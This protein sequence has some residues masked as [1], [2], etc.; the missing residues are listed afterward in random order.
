MGDRNVLAFAAK[1][2]NN[3]SGKTILYAGL[4]GSQVF[5][6][7]DLGDS[8]VDKGIFLPPR[9]IDAF[10]VCGNTIFAAGDDILFST[11]DGDSWSPIITPFSNCTLL[12]I[13]A[14]PRND[15]SGV[16]EL[17]VS[18]GGGVRLT[19]NT[20]A[21]WTIVNN[22]LPGSNV[23]SLLSVDISGM[24]HLLAGTDRG[25]VFVSTNSGTNWRN[26]SDGLT[27]LNTHKLLVNGS[28]LYAATESG[29]VFRRPLSELL[30]VEHGGELPKHFELEQNFPNPFSAKTS[31]GFSLPRTEHVMLEIYN[32]LGMKVATIVDELSAPGRRTV[33]F[34]ATSLGSGAYFAVLRTPTARQCRMITV[35]R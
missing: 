2:D 11:D 1:Q 34:D 28:F 33:S 6:S 12:D 4:S 10:T 25:G 14:R 8:W 17:F 29:G 27:D 26:V 22:G 24:P 35:M 3:Q 30:A 18:A 23:L 9:T 19:T 16:T 20:G 15:A 5:L 7:S 21:S 31:I 32:A 13:L